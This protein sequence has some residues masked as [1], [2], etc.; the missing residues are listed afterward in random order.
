MTPSFGLQALRS[1]PVTRLIGSGVAYK[2]ELMIRIRRVR[3]KN[4]DISAGLPRGAKMYRL[5]NSPASAN[6]AGCLLPL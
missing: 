1:L 4:K 3:C 6:L 2:H 5:V